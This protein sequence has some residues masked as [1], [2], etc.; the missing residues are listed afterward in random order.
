MYENSVRIIHVQFQIVL[1]NTDGDTS[2]FPIKKAL[3]HVTSILS[4]EPV[5][6]VIFKSE[7]YFCVISRN[8]L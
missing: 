3:V 6:D 1:T 2:F 8:N 5:D 7:M 4:L